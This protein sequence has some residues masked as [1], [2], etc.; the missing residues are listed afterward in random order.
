MNLTTPD[1]TLSSFPTNKQTKPQ[2]D[3]IPMK[4][5]STPSP[6]FADVTE[7]LEKEKK[8]ETLVNQF[9]QDQFYA[10][11]QRRREAAFNGDDIADKAIEDF[12]AATDGTLE[13]QYRTTREVFKTRLKNWRAKIWN[14]FTR[15]VLLHQLEELEKKRASL[16]ADLEAVSKKHGVPVVVPDHLEGRINAKRSYLQMTPAAAAMEPIRH[17][18]A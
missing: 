1:N 4:T 11:S 17:I 18:L 3:R 8:F 14:D 12:S 2:L 7:V 13:K 6:K 5:K 10:E 15:T 16:A 9:G